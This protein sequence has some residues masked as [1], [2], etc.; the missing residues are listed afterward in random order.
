VDRLGVAIIS[1]DRSHYLRR[2]L[3][4]LAQCTGAECCTFHLWQDGAVNRFSGVRHA[5]D[6]AIDASVRTFERCG[7]PRK[8]AHV[9]PDNVG[10]AIN[11]FE[12]YEWMTERYEYVLAIEDDVVV[13]PHW[14][15]LCN[16]LIAQLESGQRSLARKGWDEVF[17]F[18]LGFKRNCGKG[19]IAQHLGEIQLG[20]PHWWAECF[21]SEHWRKIRPHFLEYYALVR[22]RDYRDTPH[23]AIID[24]WRR[25]GWKQNAT[26]QDGGKDMAVHSAGLQRAVCVVN[27]GM[28]IGRNG[29]HFTPEQFAR[30][31]YEDQRP[32]VFG[33]DATRERFE[34]V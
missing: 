31:G 28:S 30:L 34:W 22:E 18:S 15:R 26:S 6:A 33:S 29:M 7:L 5:T 4:S 10:I 9:Q 1:F 14:L 32:Y 16:V 11:Q 17:G 27:R 2:L 3:G 21:P 8:E 12:A 23:A 25:K 19:E 20:T 24:L 13:S